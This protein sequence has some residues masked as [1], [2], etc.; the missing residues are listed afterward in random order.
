MLYLRPRYERS[1]I[2]PMMSRPVLLEIHNG[3]GKVRI[4]GQ[5]TT[6]CL[7]SGTFPPRP[8]QRVPTLHGFHLNEFQPARVALSVDRRFP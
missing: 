5:E 4:R 8:I 6:V 1:F 2:V 3:K 7:P